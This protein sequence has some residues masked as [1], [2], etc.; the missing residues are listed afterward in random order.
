MEA[1]RPK[2]IF[3]EKSVAHLPLAR[4]LLQA[5]PGIPVQEIADLRDFKS[6]EPMTEAK[7]LLYIAQYRGEA[8]KP[9]PKVKYAFNLGDYVF[10]PISN[11]HLECRYCILQSY[12]KN[13]PGLTVFANLDHFFKA[14]EKKIKESDQTFLRMGTGE[15][16][17]SLALDDL[18][19]LSQ[20]LVPFF[21]KQKKAFLELK[22]KSNRIDHLLNLDH[23][24]QTVISVSLSPE[25]IVREEELKCAS[26]A[27]RLV[28]AKSL[29]DRGYA[30]GLH[31]DPLIYFKGWEE[32]YRDLVESIS[33]NINPKRLAWL[34]LGSLRFDPDLK[35]EA[36]ER[37]P[38]T[39]IFS[40]DFL[41]GEDKKYRYFKKIRLSM[42]QKILAYLRDYSTDFP[43]YLCMEA[44][45]VWEEVM[46]EAPSVEAFEEKL[47]KRLQ[48]LA[49][50]SF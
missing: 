9:F 3:L 47:G 17:D 23:R 22:T 5:L 15:L 31:L 21:A 36:Q 43:R 18:T 40:G 1:Y 29:Q 7:R 2:K 49:K 4:R 38:K 26:L 25:K 45:W 33:Q 28:A 44:P 13:N 16:S 46:G 35:K 10:N 39:K 24:G 34:S 27:E 19:R 30:V 6:P 32:S 20:D 42:Y 8:L 14:I 41:L 50:E 37:F 12:L 11:C 48:A